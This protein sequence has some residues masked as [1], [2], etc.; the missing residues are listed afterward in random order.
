VWVAGFV[1][2]RCPSSCPV[3]TKAM[4]DLR[5]SLDRGGLD[6]GMVS[7][8]VDPEHDTPEVLARHAADVGAD[9]ESWRWVTGD[10]R[11]IRA[12]VVDGFRLGVG[13]REPQAGDLYDIAHSTKLA[14][15]DSSGGVR[16]YY[17]IEPE[18]LEEIFHR[19]MHVMREE[20]AA[21]SP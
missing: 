5:E 8:S 9:G 13:H 4:A 11:A 6:V 19:A 17:G 12:L 16:G 21:E 1:F 14:L 20:R 7:I 3:V 15:V 10:L 2:T 18:A